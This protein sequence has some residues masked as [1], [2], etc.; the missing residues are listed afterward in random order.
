MAQ[1][2]ISIEQAETV[3]ESALDIFFELQ[4]NFG[5]DRD[6]EFL[7]PREITDAVRVAWRRSFPGELDTTK[8]RQ[9]F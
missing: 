8:M 9:L 6:W 2:L 7:D 3:L 4:G 5:M 1:T